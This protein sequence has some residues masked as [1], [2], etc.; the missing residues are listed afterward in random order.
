MLA[1]IY[2]NLIILIIISLAKFGGIHK[3]L[4]SEAMKLELSARIWVFKESY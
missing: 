1:I 3:C 2:S 4:N